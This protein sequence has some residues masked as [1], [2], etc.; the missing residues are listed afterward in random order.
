[1]EGGSGSDEHAAGLLSSTTSSARRPCLIKLCYGD[2]RVLLTK[3]STLQDAITYARNRFELKNARDYPNVDLTFELDGQV[4][5]IGD[6]AA[7]T[8]V[9]D[10]AVV[11]VRAKKV[12]MITQDRVD[13]IYTCR[14][15][16][17][18]ALDLTY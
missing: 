2:D 6:T 10:M 14:Q 18:F 1:M 8:L 5:T 3:T 12:R 9:G 4:F 7:W 17:L 13:A 15:Y 11:D 16:S